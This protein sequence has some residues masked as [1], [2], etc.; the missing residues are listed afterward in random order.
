[1]LLEKILILAGE[2][3]LI[4]L[5][6]TNCLCPLEVETQMLQIL[7]TESK[8]FLHKLKKITHSFI[9]QFILD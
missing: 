7:V 3:W 4:S 5:L 2:V 8:V 1:M 6:P 9:S